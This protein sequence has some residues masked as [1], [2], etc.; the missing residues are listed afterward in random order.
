[1]GSVMEVVLESE[2]AVNKVGDKSSLLDG[3]VLLVKEGIV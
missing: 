3:L 1:M 2:S